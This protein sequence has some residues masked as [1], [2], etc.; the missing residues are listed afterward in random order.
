MAANGAAARTT[1]TLVEAEA[2]ADFPRLRRIPSSTVQ[3]F[4]DYYRGLADAETDE[5]RAALAER[6]AL[7]LRP[8]P[9]R[10]FP[11]SPAYD[12]WAQAKLASGFG[13]GARYQ[14]L[15]LAKNIVSAALAGESN[16]DAESAE[17]L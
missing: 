2:A 15:R 5:L 14:P 8:T 11:S 1:H 16:L 13:P 4:L 3:H 6:G 10:A 12:R 9:G 17:G 7:T